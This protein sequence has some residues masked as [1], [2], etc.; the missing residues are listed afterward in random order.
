MTHCVIVPNSLRDKIYE[1]VDAAIAKVPEAS[2]DREEFYQ[3]VLNYFDVHGTLP[4]IELR[5]YDAA[6]QSSSTKEIK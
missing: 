5:R 2:V 6:S 4:E 3:T 1:L